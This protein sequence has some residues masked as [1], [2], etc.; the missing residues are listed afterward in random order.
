MTTQ[1]AWG[2]FA[3]CSFLLNFVWESW[4]AVWLYRGFDEPGLFAVESF[5]HFVRMMTRVSLTDAAL[6]LV[7]AV[8]GAVVWRDR[9]WLLHRDTRRQWY[10]IGAALLLAAIIEIKAVFLWQQWS[11]TT[12]MPTFFGLG[13]SPLLQLAATGIAAWRLA[14]PGPSV[15][16]DTPGERA[17][18]EQARLSYGEKRYYS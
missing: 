7:I 16:P 18:E 6:L 13:V 17:L 2:R 3:L 14:V 12:L 5:R 11:Y 9:Q 10:L 1:T 15:P 4:H 8:T